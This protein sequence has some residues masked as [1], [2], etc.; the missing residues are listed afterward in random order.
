MEIGTLDDVPALLD[1]STVDEARR[2]AVWTSSAPS[3]FP[4]LSVDIQAG[5]PVGN[6]RCVAMGNATLWS[7]RSSPAVVNY[8]PFDAMDEPLNFTLLLQMDGRTDVTQ[9]RRKCGM[10]AG[11][12]CLLDERFSFQM[13]GP[14]CSEILFLRMP[15]SAVLNRNPHLEHQTAIL[16]PSS[17][18][19]V[20][21]LGETLVN[22]IHTVPFMREHQ[23]HAALLAIIHLLGAAETAKGDASCLPNWRVQS[24]LAHIEL[25]FAVPGL[26]AEQVAQ[27][28]RIS[29]RR[30]DQLMIEAT[31]ASITGCIWNQRLQQAAADLCDPAR[32]SLTAAQI[33][34]ANGFED[35]AHFARAFKRRYDCSPLRWRERGSILVQ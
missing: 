27:A 33:A 26:S 29:R 18:A 10:A 19:G 2:S 5:A 32:A 35:P 14:G 13:E 22:A 30:L 16:M 6:I 28:Q 17:D 8:L 4:G 34:F 15:R 7:I 25:N 11:D 12:I 3:I 9:R 1:L 31:G 21:L 24:A 20:S 23:R